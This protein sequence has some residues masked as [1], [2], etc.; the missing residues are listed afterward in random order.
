MVINNWVKDP[1]SN[2]WVRSTYSLRG[3][4]IYNGGV[5]GGVPERTV[6]RYSVIDSRYG[7]VQCK[8]VSLA[9]LDEFTG[10][11]P[12]HLKYKQ[13]QR[14]DLKIANFNGTLEEALQWTGIDQQMDWQG[15]L[16]V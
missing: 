2:I 10:E 3:D 7:F 6:G 12:V 5:R 8:I 14:V 16:L 11:Y 15:G 1:D 4:I 9:M 13:G